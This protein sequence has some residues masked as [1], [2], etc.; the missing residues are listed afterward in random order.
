MRTLVVGVVAAAL[1]ATGPV[2]SLPTAAAPAPTAVADP[3]T[4][5]A[6]RLAAQLVVSCVDVGRA[7]WVGHARQHSAAGVG[8]IVLLGSPAPGGLRRSLR[9]VRAATP[10][11]PGDSRR[12]PP[13]IASDEE[14]GAVQRLSRLVYPLPA[15]ATMGRWTPARV[16]RTAH[17]YALRMRR[18]GVG[19]DL[20]PVVDLAVP[21]SYL[22]NLGRSFAARPGPVA[23]RARA[24]RL[25]MR[26][27]G[28]VTVLKHWPG[29]G[30]ARN[31]HTG[32][33]RVAPL[34]EL[35]RW[36]L[37]PFERE[38]ADGAPVVMVG[39]LLSRG[40]TRDGTPTSL[41]RRAL[42]YLRRSAGPEVV[43]LTDSLTMAAATSAVGATPVEATVRA[44]R[45][46]ADWA[47]VCDGDALRA[48]G[49]VR[50]ALL[51][52]S[53]PRARAEASARRVL[54]IKASAGLPPAP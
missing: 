27:A 49:A 48:I 29:H 4:W 19:M 32:P 30:S 5:S 10:R 17:D 25:G 46:G 8:A 15:A 39:H 26:D 9:E 35:Q 41:S 37:M 44:L 43:I 36:D 38:L 51:D 53:L 13:M 12:V 24:W 28:V 22:D 7:G 20:A 3:A 16:R 2:A 11:A 54:A 50:R 45:A 42:T 52:G 31:T 21:G 1:L 14:G 33:G 6:R 18:L 23:E 47:M 34:S 40:L